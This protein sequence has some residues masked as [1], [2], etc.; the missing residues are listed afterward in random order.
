M[1]KIMAVNA[2]SSSLKFQLLEMPEEKLVVSGIVEK[3]G[4]TTE[5]GEYSFKINVKKVLEGKEEVKDHARAVEIV[6]EGLMKLKVIDSFD[7]ISG[8]GHRVVQGGPYFSGSCLVT[9]DVK[10]KIAELIPLAP[11][12]N[13]PHLIGI[14]AFEKILPNVPNVVVFDTAFHQTMDELSYLY[15]TPYEWYTDYKVRKYGAHGTSHQYVANTLAETIGKDVKDLKIITCH[16]GN[17]ASLTAVKGGKCVDTSMGLTPLDGFPMGTRSGHMDPTVLRYMHDQ[18]GY[19]FDELITILN[20]KSGYLGISGVSHDSR[21]LEECMK[22]GSEPNATKEDKEKARRCKLAYDVQI[23]RIV[24]YVAA[25]YVLMEGCDA[26][27]FTAGIGENSAYL[28]SGICKRVKVLG[29]EIDEKLNADP[30]I[31]GKI[32]KISTDKSKVLVYIIPTNEELVIARDVMRLT[33]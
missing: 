4:A 8:I 30:S 15:G 19:S 28:R 20:Y 11:L 10:A 24:D 22:K 21:M 2:G 33:K 23:K 32:Q 16:I 25:Y 13:K 5:I 14:E 3:V 27:V 26:I 18:K 1:R 7:E 31:R 29:V 6:L 17:G 9:E 12:H